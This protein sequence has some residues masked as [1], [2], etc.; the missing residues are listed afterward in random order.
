[1]PAAGDKVLAADVDDIEEATTGKPIVRLT[2]QSTQNMTN[3]TNTAITFGA[4]SEDIDTHGY[5]DTTSNTSRVT[6]TKE[7]Y[8][9]VYGVVMFGARADY[10]NVSAW[11][12]K[13]GSSNL[14][15]GQR[16]GPSSASSQVHSPAARAIVACNGT[17]DYVE[18]V[19]IQV[20]AAVATQATN[21]SSQF[22]CMLEVTYD[23]P[24]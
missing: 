11:I 4:S 13:N 12:R 9:I 10:T 2:A 7:G 23:R 6:P 24:L 19:G 14:A 15:G 20:N 3:N 22:S 5:H 1:M 18:L 8:Y 17:T 16:F 21:N